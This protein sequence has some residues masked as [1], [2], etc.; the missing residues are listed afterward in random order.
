MSNALK[1]TA[2]ILLLL[3]S[4]QTVQPI[5]AQVIGQNWEKPAFDQNNT[6]FSPQTQINKENV[7]QLALK[8]I[9]QVPEST[10]RIPFAS[11]ALGIQTTPLVVNGIMYAATPFNRLVAL[12]T[13]NGGELWSFEAN[14]SQIAQN[15]NW[16]GLLIQNSIAHHNGMIWMQTVDCTVYG[17]DPQTG[18]KKMV[19]TDTCV[20]IS[21]NTG[22]Y[23]GHYAPVFYKSTLITR[24]SGGATGGRGFVAGYDTNT[25]K[26]LWRWYSVPPSGGDPDWDEKTGASKGNIAA[27]KGDWGQ[28]DLIGGG[29]VWALIAVDEET[30]VIYFPT[31]TPGITYDASLRPG[32]NLYSNSIVAL[33]ASDGEMLWYYQTTPHDVN[34]DEPGIG[35]IVTNVKIGDTTKKVIMAGTKGDWVYFLDAKTG[36]PIF[37]PLEVGSK[38][39]NRFNQN[40]GN[41][42]NFTLSQ[43]VYAKNIF[44]PG[45]EGGIESYLGFAYNTL[46]VASQSLCRTLLAGKVPYKGRII[47]GFTIQPA[48]GFLQNSTLYAVDV[49]TGTIKWRFTMPNRYQGGVTVSN[50]IVFLMDIAGVF[51]AIDADTGQ[52][53]NRIPLNAAGVSGVSLGHD[54]RGQMTI[55]LASG[56]ARPGIIVALAP[57]GTAP[58][59]PSVTET[60]T[61]P[62]S[63]SGVITA[64]GIVI[65]AISIAAVSLTYAIILSRS[66]RNKR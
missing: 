33:N 24:A 31:G 30:G 14:I 34:G 41:N 47:D 45:P 65:A 5:E 15:P 50:G 36:K 44:C 1:E 40:L 51:Y 66:K 49:S 4:L 18:D 19:I 10:E 43:K 64:S 61:P 16:G 29:A 6:S 3:L 58:L 46:Y 63:F 12:N 35:V 2:I 54:A 60:R 28:S 62:S 8:W 21:G 42:A 59:T 39:I 52:M 23:V 32:P 13:I 9:Y 27:Y 26:L 22:K 56:G 17:F 37:N 53:L 25:G 11:I 48:F 20:N 7:K 55:F 38:K 57:T